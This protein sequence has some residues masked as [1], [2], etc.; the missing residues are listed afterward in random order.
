MVA[1][2]FFRFLGILL[3]DDLKHVLC[4]QNGVNK[5]EELLDED[6]RSDAFGVRKDFLECSPDVVK[7]SSISVKLDQPTFFFISLFVEYSKC[8]LVPMPIPINHR[9]VGIEQ[10]FKQ[11]SKS[12]KSL[13]E[14]MLAESQTE[15]QDSAL[16]SFFYE[17]MPKFSTANFTGTSL[18]SGTKHHVDEGVLSMT[19]P[20]NDPTH[21]ACR[22]EPIA[23]LCQA[24]FVKPGRNNTPS[25]DKY[26]NVEYESLQ[27]KMPSKETYV[28]VMKLFNKSVKLFD[29]T[30][31][32]G[33]NMKSTE[34]YF[35]WKPL[36]NGDFMPTG[37]SLA[38][39]QQFVDHYELGIDLSGFTDETLTLAHIEV[40]HF[41]QSVVPFRIG[42]VEGGHRFEYA[43]RT[44]YGVPLEQKLTLHHPEGKPLSLRP[45]CVLVQP[46]SMRLVQFPMGEEQITPLIIKGLRKKSFGILNMQQTQIET[47]WRQLL[48][49]LSNQLPEAVPN[50][51]EQIPGHCKYFQYNQP[52]A[53]GA[54]DA[55]NHFYTV[56]AVAVVKVLV[57]L[58]KATN[59]SRE[60]F[61]N[62]E[63]F[64]KDSMKAADQYMHVPI[65][66]ASFLWPSSTDLLNK[67]KITGIQG[68]KVCMLSVLWMFGLFSHTQ[69]LWTF[70]KKFLT[71]T[72]EVIH[73]PSFMFSYIMGVSNAIGNVARNRIDK[74]LSNQDFKQKMG[75]VVAKKRSFMRF[76]IKQYFRMSFAYQIM[77]TLMKI[78]TKKPHVK[79]GFMKQAAAWYEKNA[80]KHHARS[81]SD[82]CRNANWAYHGMT[83][84]I[85]LA[86]SDYVDDNFVTSMLSHYRTC[87]SKQASLMWSLFPAQF[88][89]DPTGLNMSGAQDSDLFVL[90][91]PEDLRVTPDLVMKI[92]EGKKDW[93]KYL[94]RESFFGGPVGKAS[95]TQK[96]KAAR[97][98]EVPATPSVADAVSAASKHT[99]GT[100]K[101]T[102]DT[103]IDQDVEDDDL[104][105]DSEDLAS[106]VAR[107]SRKRKQPSQVTK[108][109]TIPPV[110]VAALMPDSSIDPNRFKIPPQGV[111]MLEKHGIPPYDEPED[112]TPA[113]KRKPTRSPKHKRSP[114]SDIKRADADDV[115]SLYNS[116]AHMSMWL[117]QFAGKRSF[118]TNMSQRIHQFVQC[119]EAL[120]Q[121][122]LPPYVFNHA[123]EQY[124]SP[125][126][127]ELFQLPQ[128]DEDNTE[129]AGDDEEHQENPEETTPPH[130]EEFD[131]VDEEHEENSKNDDSDYDPPQSDNGGEEDLVIDNDVD[132]NE[133]IHDDEE[134]GSGDSDGAV[135]PDTEGNADDSGA[136]NP[137]G[138][139]KAD[140]PRNQNL[141]HPNDKSLAD[142]E[143]QGNV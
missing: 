58:M 143:A 65:A 16:T 79:T 85:L 100:E 75:N 67:I 26:C 107:A 119:A 115:Q 43:I 60:L 111:A 142:G 34:T 19:V 91:V 138:E 28:S 12:K 94:V 13:H 82:V 44:F 70:F 62:D 124:H 61:V 121:L 49:N 109:A 99:K 80:Y 101:A 30:I 133:E 102:V 32:K 104:Y 90:L 96:Q 103:S 55:G 88:G 23:S 93:R 59:P 4:K 17:V 125:M 53:P 54:K 7:E 52:D 87:N 76:A 56:R 69:E 6:N 98:V 78:G 9:F 27:Y 112:E 141:D 127:E 71:S 136:G 129:S 50:W 48:C 47:S 39:L 64:E 21:T 18:R 122:M 33:D 131:N 140:K 51:A 2:Y 8:F 25:I 36:F 105:E 68:N 120:V 73:D 113:K 135:N 72:D 35:D 84:P 95:P 63:D 31:E 117:R 22:E 137:D 139:D 132:K 15:L 41:I 46:I 110:A 114:R 42:F 77:D 81:R 1:Y 10:L 128:D 134:D 57:S 130:E 38:N 3:N 118:Q 29:Y 116:F 86:W 108:A 126:V 106:A 14:A 83:Q 45:E 97:I 40:R 37:A 92:L 11:S 24:C 5:I 74:V 20:G 66:T 89:A 123:S